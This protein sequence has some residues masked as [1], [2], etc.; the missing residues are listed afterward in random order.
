MSPVFNETLEAEIIARHASVIKFEL[1]DSNAMQKDVPLGNA[2]F[3]LKKLV[4][5]E[6]T[7]FN[8]LLQNGKGSL[9]IRL[10]FDPQDITTKGIDIGARRSS[11]AK[12]ARNFTRQISFQQSHKEPLPKN[13]YISPSMTNLTGI[14]NKSKSAINSIEHLN[15]I[16]PNGS[17]T[18]PNEELS[19]D[20]TRGESPTPAS[21]FNVNVVEAE[22]ESGRITPV[23]LPKNNTHT[24]A[25]TSLSNSSTSS[26]INDLKKSMNSPGSSTN[27]LP[28]AFLDLNRGL[29]PT[30]VNDMTISI[31]IHAATGI[32]AVNSNGFSDPYVKVF[33]DSSHPKSFYKTAVVKKN[34]NPIWANEHFNFLCSQSGLL[35]LIMD[36]NSLSK[37]VRIGHVHIDLAALFAESSVFDQWFDVQDGSGKLHISGSAVPLS[38][39]ELMSSS[40]ST[41]PAF[42]PNRKSMLSLG[43]V[44]S[45]PSK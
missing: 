36:H 41:R 13:V 10:F 17:S 28:T 4:P 29:E 21:K 44:F 6:V 14:G 35:F 38:T 33:K 34:L 24:R 26:F 23:E 12:V 20:Y 8:L 43:K 11:V 15:R 18:E 5:G 30:L 7:P 42:N 31:K 1:F 19:L 37:N 3:D 40:S 39:D 27:S 22:S 45:R 25:L 16:R 9:S 32:Q 2:V